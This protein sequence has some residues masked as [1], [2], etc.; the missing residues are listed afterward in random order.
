MRDQ[1][2]QPAQPDERITSFISSQ[3]VLTMAVCTAGIPYCASCFYAY[4][5]EHNMLVFKSSKET[6]HTS[7]GLLNKRVSGTVLPDKLLKGKVKGVQFQGLFLQPEGDVL[8]DLQG[9]YYR[10]YPFAMA[11]GG[12]I[13]AI[14][15]RWIKF[16]D[17]TLGF[18]KKVTWGEEL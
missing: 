16:T 11:M 8:S 2:P 5:E 18:G 6:R 12:D 13:W 7:A 15:L 4:N 9:V 1:Q 17:N 3:T 10:K 14:E